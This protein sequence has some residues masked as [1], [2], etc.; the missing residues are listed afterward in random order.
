MLLTRREGGKELGGGGKI[1]RDRGRF[2]GFENTVRKGSQ[3]AC[4][5]GMVRFIPEKFLEESN[6]GGIKKELKA[7]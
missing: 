4:L 6:N 1:A 3:S 7:L 2:W 5:E